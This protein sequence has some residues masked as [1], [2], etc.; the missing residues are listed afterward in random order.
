MFIIWLGEQ[1]DFKDNV[2]GYYLFG[3]S[4]FCGFASIVR[5]NNNNKHA[6]PDKSPKLLDIPKYEKCYKRSSLH[7]LENFFI[8]FLKQISLSLNNIQL[9]FM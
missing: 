5:N 9:K 7:N 1:N 3:Y 6:T 4:Y 8:N 2:C